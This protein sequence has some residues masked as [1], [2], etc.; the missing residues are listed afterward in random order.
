MEIRDLIAEKRKASWHQTRDPQDKTELNNLAQQLRRGIKELKKD[1]ISAYL[2][3]LTNDN[4]S[5]YSL[6]KANKNIKRPVMQIS[7]I[8]ETDGKWARNTEQKA[9]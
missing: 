7:P 1:S 8:R 3:E 4:N 9:Q 5:D 2:S 6:W